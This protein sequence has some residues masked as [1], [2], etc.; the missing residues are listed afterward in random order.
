[1]SDVILGV[2]T[3]IFMILGYLLPWVISKIRRHHDSLAIF[4]LNTL[5]GWTLLGWVVALIWALTARRM[6]VA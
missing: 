2:I 1:M 5:L 6:G 3:V 4:W